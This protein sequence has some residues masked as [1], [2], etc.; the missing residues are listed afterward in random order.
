MPYTA[1]V[2]ASAANYMICDDHEFTDDL[3]EKASLASVRDWS[4]LFCHASARESCFQDVRR[5]M[6][7]FIILLESLT[8]DDQDINLLCED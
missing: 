5:E 2:L 4:G 1:K 7:N 8:L 3:G 6:R